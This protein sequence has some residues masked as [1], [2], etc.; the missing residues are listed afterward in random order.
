MQSQPSSPINIFNS[1]SLFS[2]Q[3][4][5]PNGSLTY[6][7]NGIN[8]LMNLVAIQALLPFPVVPVLQSMPHSPHSISRSFIYPQCDLIQKLFRWTPLATEESCF[9]LVSS[10]KRCGNLSIHSPI[11]R[12]RPHSSSCKMQLNNCLS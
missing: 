4:N 2:N 7:R 8:Y 10:L 1:V 5:S 3:K 12:V 11:I 9:V 6:F